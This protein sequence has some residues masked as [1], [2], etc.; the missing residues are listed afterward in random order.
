MNA[1][2]FNEVRDEILGFWIRQSSDSGVL[3]CKKGIGRP[4][5]SCD[6]HVENKAVLTLVCT[7]EMSKVDVFAGY[8]FDMDLETIKEKLE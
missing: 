8:L 1:T 7:S 4:V 6:L 2:R 5:L 3:G